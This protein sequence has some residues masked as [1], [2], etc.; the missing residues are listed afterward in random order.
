MLPNR[1]SLAVYAA[2]TVLVGASVTAVAT[3]AWAVPGLVAVTVTSAEVG[4]ESF[5]G[6]AAECPAGTKIVGGGAD[7]QGGNHSVRVAGINPAPLLPNPNAL[8]ATA[9]EDLLGYAGSWSLVAWAICAPGLVGWE[10]VLADA[11]GP[12]NSLAAATATCPAG[13]K[14]IGAGGRSAGKVSV[15][16]DSIN[17][18]A[19]L[20]SVT[21]EVMAINGATPVAH[22]YAICINTVPG[23][24]LVELNSR[25]RSA[26]QTVA[27]SCPAGTKVHGVGGGLTGASGQSYIDELGPTGV[28]L[29][30]V[31]IDARED[32]TGN[33]SPWSAKVQA[34]CAT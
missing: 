4:S 27:L 21:V 18:A 33:P 16:L 20:N 26:D 23:Q 32:V 8:W 15:V 12:T 7:V 3:P 24:Q 9:H 22:A 31:F 6:V 25:S 10:V 2:I 19:D 34:V 1:S 5:K 28:S 11:T 14:V 29:T 13:K 30:S 17:I